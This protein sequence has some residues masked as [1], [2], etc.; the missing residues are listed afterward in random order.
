MLADF[1]LSFPSRDA[2]SRT[3][4]EGIHSLPPAHFLVV[5]REELT[6]RRYFDFDT[7][8]RS[9]SSAWPDYVDAFP[10]A[11]LRLVCAIVCEV[12]RPWL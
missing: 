4:F 7:S 6:S 5:T 10:R 3:F 1:V 9:D 8:G 2:A 12:P 11:V